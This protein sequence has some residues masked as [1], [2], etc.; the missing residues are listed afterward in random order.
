MNENNRLYYSFF[1][2]ADNFTNNENQERGGISWYNFTSTLRWNHVFNKR[3]FSNT[4]LYASRYDYTLLTGG[5]TWGSGISN[6]SL[7]LDFTYYPNP[8]ETWKFGF[9]ETGHNINPG[10]LANVENNP[11]IP[12]IA[13]SQAAKTVLYINR[14]N[15]LNERFSYKAGLRMPLW[16]NIGPTTLYQFDS[17]YQVS[18]TIIFQKGERVKSFV[19]L[20]PRISIKYQLSNTTSLKASWG[21]Y[22][23]FLNLIT[24]SISPF[25]SFEIWMPA[26]SNLRPQEASQVA[27]GMVSVFPEKHWELTQELYYKKMKNQL[28]YEPHASLLL[29]PL[30]EGEL[31]FGNA[32]SY[33]YEFLLRRTRG[34]LTGWI[35]YTWSRSLKTIQDVNNNEQFPTYY[36]RP[37]DL[38]VFISWHVSQKINFSAN[39]IYYTGS[40][41]TTPTGFYSYN[42]YTVPLYAEKNNDRLPDYHRLDV[43][44]AWQL[45]KPERKYQHSLSLAIYNLYNRHNAI[46]INFNKMRTKNGNYV[47]PANLYGTPHI[48]TTQKYLLG[49]MPSITYKFKI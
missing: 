20:D 16:N 32:Q 11:F 41:I 30:I 12:H 49:I 29:N 10:N 26:N 2:G 15:K 21:I 35:S 40:A 42:G 37:H 23:Q 43:A 1:Y 34:R 48:F 17:S 9:S 25:S 39:W 31:R 27:L 18:D 5:T 8:G 14:E 13:K 7:N 36:D 38:S 24:N 4:T 44:I 33:G 47:V 28:D 46:S 22:H 19:R 45:N 3:L 6:L